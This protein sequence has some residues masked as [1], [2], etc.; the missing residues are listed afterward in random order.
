MI[1]EPPL[2]VEVWGE[3]A[4]F[5]RPE[6]GVERVSYEVMTPSAAR[7]ILEA[8]FWKPEFRWVVREIAVLR[9]IRHFSILRNEMNSTQSERSARSWEANGGGY[10]ADEDRA[11]RHTLCLRDVAYRIRADIELKAHATDNVAKYRDQFRRRVKR[12]QCFNQ[13]YLGTREFSAFFGPPNGE[14]K[15]VDVTDDLGL[16]LLDMDF[17]PDG[18]G[19][20]S[21]AEHGPEGRKIVK[22]N[23]RPKFFRAR[24]EGGVLK[25]PQE[26]SGGRL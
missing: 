5:T 3:F 24:L 1:Y 16:M 9:P 12:G 6:F 20:V 25:V 8:I 21:Y 10:F 4:C 13:P 2:E 7:G 11:Q 26:T 18:K 17:E 15:P 22:A 14:Q 23:A 19:R